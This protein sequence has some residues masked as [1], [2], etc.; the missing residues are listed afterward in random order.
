MVLQIISISL[1]A[2]FLIS[3]IGD[4]IAISKQE[5]QL[6]AMYKEQKE[7]YEKLNINFK[8]KN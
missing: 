4:L 6:K 7:I 2:T 3:V 8:E 1:L 5:K